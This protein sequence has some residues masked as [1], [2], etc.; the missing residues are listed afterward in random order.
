[1]SQ[2]IKYGIIGTGHLGKFHVQQMQKIKLV[3]VVGCYDVDLDLCYQV[4]KA[5]GLQ[6][7]KS[8]KKLL[9]ACDAI[10]IAT[11]ASSHFDVAKMGL[12]Q[13]CHLFIE[14]PITNNLK[15]A[16]AL[17]KQAK[18]HNKIIQVGHIERFNPAFL[19][20]TKKQNPNPVYIEGNR[21]SPFSER[22]LDV[23]VVLDLMIHDIDLVLSLVRCKVKHIHAK[24]IKV[25]SNQTDLASARIEFEN[26][27]V[28]NL[29]ASRISE[30]KL[31]KMRVF[32][33][34][35]Y[36]SLDFNSL[37]LEQYKTTNYNKN[38]NFVFYN[39]SRAIQHHK[40]AATPNNALYEELVS[41]I[42]SIQANTNQVKVSA[43]EA[44]LALTIALKIEK[45]INNQK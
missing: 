40:Q 11:P 4:C 16:K 27:A 9:Q 15:Q 30:K 14:K 10:S 44:T 6:A 33:Q 18:L 21:L 1:M 26:G 31:R 2:K 25:L 45:I 17:I 41:F 28:A 32:E 37:T 36:T 5:S 39:Q 42:N 24:G 35:Q 22:G 34:N 7:F 12:E 23:N 43:E 13:Q 8:L 19:L 3:E 38:K 29:V 20:Y